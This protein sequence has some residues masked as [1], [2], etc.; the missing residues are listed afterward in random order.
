[1]ITDFSSFLV[2]RWLASN[3]SAGQICRIRVWAV[4]F[5]F[6][7][8]LSN[9]SKTILDL[10]AIC[11]WKSQANALRTFPCPRSRILSRFTTQIGSRLCRAPRKWWFDIFTVYF[12]IYA[13]SYLVSSRWISHHFWQHRSRWGGQSSS[14]ILLRKGSAKFEC[15]ERK[16]AKL[17][18][19][20]HVEYGTYIKLFRVSSSSCSGY[21]CQR[22]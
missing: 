22:Q 14:R 20:L 3:V 17:V 4:C 2:C 16:Y 15:I 21:I 1:M 8:S 13:F 12:N 9:N 6:S 11:C 19:V 10:C 7:I 18:T 5:R